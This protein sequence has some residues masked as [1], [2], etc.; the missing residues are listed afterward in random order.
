MTPPLADQNDI[1]G[2]QIVRHDRGEHA[3]RNVLPL[4]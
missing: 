4:P 3:E 2:G 1:A